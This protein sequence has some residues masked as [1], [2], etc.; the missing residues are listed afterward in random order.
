MKEVQKN[1]KTAIKYATSKNEYMMSN[2]KV[3][4][5]FAKYDQKRMRGKRV[6]ARTLFRHYE[7]AYNIT[8]VPHLKDAII[9][10]EGTYELTIEKDGT[11]WCVGYKDVN[12]KR[13]SWHKGY[14]FRSVSLANCLL[15]LILEYHFL[16]VPLS[17]LYPKEYGD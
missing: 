17:I 6:S 12:V 4:M 8:M 9:E 13:N 5:A 15:D 7:R 16:D 2:L 11:Q 14:Y 10:K 1:K 3:L